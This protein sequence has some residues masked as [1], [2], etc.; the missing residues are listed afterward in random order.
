M[1]VHVSP[2]HRNPPGPIISTCPCCGK[3]SYF[4]GMTTH[5]MGEYPQLMLPSYPKVVGTIASSYA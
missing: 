2:P 4:Y 5:G 3:V 1:G